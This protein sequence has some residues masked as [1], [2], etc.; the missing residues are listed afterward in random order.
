M[1]VHWIDRASLTRRK[2]I[3]ACRRIAGRLPC[4]A[5]AKEIDDIHWGFQIGSKVSKITVDNG[6]NSTKAF[7]YA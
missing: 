1:A 3:L 5:L 2:A 4:H 6:S 7:K